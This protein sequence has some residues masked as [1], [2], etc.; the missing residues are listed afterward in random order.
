MEQIITIQ[1]IR[2]NYANLL[3]KYRG[4]ENAL[5]EKVLAKERQLARLEAKRKLL[6]KN[7]PRWTEALVIP[8]IDQLKNS[9]PGWTY[10]GEELIPM[11]LGCRVAVF[12]YKD[13]QPEIVD[14][15]AEDNS[16]YICFS[17]GDLTTGELLYTTTAGDKYDPVTKPIESLE[18]LINH[19]KSQIIEN[20]IQ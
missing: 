16:I 5:C 10:D 3:A 15:Y 18:E 7:F 2:K 17:P 6:S 4:E 9:I 12:F 8:I 20:K 13:D 1:E 19:L 11:G 14:K